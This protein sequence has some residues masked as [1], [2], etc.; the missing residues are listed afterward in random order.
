MDFLYS[1]YKWHLLKK[2]NSI[3]FGSPTLEKVWL[4][5]K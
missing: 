1:G 4:E 3:K 5:N 2:K